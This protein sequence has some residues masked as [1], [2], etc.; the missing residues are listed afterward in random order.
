MQTAAAGLS[1]PAA[2]L[3]TDPNGNRTQALFDALGMLAGTALQGKAAGPVEGDSFDTFTPDLAPREIAAFFDA[4]DPRALA[5][6]LSWHCDDTH[7]L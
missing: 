4:P 1:R 2:D 6:T 7:R 3:V 5:V